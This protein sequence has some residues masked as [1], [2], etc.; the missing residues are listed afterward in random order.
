M[1]LAQSKPLLNGG[2]NETLREALANEARAQP[3]KLR[4]RILDRGIRGAR[5]ETRRRF[6]WL[7]AATA[8][9]GEGQCVTP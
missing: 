6:Y 4:H 7:T 9:I 1:A 5:S 3:G 8:R 2:G